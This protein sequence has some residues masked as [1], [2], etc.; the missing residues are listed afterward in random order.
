MS[1]L[2]KTLDIY[3]SSQKLGVGSDRA[4][5]LRANEVNYFKTNTVNYI[6]PATLFSINLHK[7]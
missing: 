5:H 6:T 1:F 2:F 3:L 4:A 7:F